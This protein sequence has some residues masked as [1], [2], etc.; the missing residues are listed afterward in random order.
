MKYYT[1]KIC[2]KVVSQINAHLKKS[3]FIS[4]QDYYD[5]FILKNKLPVC[6]YC[7]KNT[8]NFISIN[9]GY[10]QYCCKDCA[11]RAALQN[12]LTKYDVENLSQ[13]PAIATKMKQSIK[14]NWDSLNKEQYMQRC[15]N[16]S[17][18]TKHAMVV[19][20]AIL[21][22]DKDKF[23]IEFDC[24][25]YAEL[26]QQYG[27]GWYQ[28]K[29]N[30][31]VQL[32]KENTLKY[33]GKYFLKNSAIYDVIE[34]Y[35]ASPKSTHSISCQEQA[36]FEYVNNICSKY[37][38]KVVQHNRSIIYPYELDI[39]IPVLRL[40]IEYNGMYW[41]NADLVGLNY[42]KDKSILCIRKDI[43]LVHI[44]EWEYINDKDKLYNYLKHTI[45][46][47][48]YNKNNIHNKLQHYSIVE[49]YNTTLIN[50]FIV[51]YYYNY[52]SLCNSTTKHYGVYDS[53]N[54]LIHIFGLSMYKNNIVLQY[55]ISNTS[56]IYTNLFDIV[57]SYIRTTF[58]DKDIQYIVN[59]DKEYIVSS[60]HNNLNTIA[61]PIL[62][63]Q[64]KHAV[65][66]A[67]YT[68]IQI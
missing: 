42:H 35:I 37:N 38:Y 3:H 20:N 55:S 23:S 58:K 27:S 4:P 13:V 41:H 15:T 56:Y 51:Q 67:G 2:D 17:K 68:Y 62:V 18:G 57:I 32:V 33:K 46:L 64:C 40:A 63:K 8:P 24:T 26:I 60:A 61:A 48:H 12:T 14:A 49:I 29:D 47:A 54:E 1:C 31:Q 7:N 59:L 22:E 9:Y 30:T 25:S 19:P 43:Q 53:Y 34:K 52:I 10:R 45:E 16:I 6:L 66:I 39:F 21:K 50:D 44:Y 36:I 11:R 5:I 65:Y 28:S